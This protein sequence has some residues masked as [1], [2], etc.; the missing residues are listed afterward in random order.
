M[1]SDEQVR[2]EGQDY[3]QAEEEATVEMVQDSPGNTP[4]EDELSYVS[5]A[6]F[7]PKAPEYLRYGQRSIAA[8]LP[9]VDSEGHYDGVE[10]ADTTYWPETCYYNEQSPIN[11]DEATCTFSGEFGFV[12]ANAT[13]FRLYRDPYK[14]YIQGTFGK[15]NV[16]GSQFSC[17]QMD[18]HYPSEHTVSALERDP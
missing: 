7:G 11:V 1:T 16:N 14:V 12:D 17:S 5:T 4:E 18:F 6:V 3:L 8:G 9:A 2:M 10:I 15:F 13:S